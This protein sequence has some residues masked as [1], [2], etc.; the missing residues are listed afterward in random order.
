M[1]ILFKPASTLLGKLVMIPSLFC[2]LEAN[3]NPYALED[4]TY[5]VLEPF[6]YYF[7][8]RNTQPPSLVIVNNISGSVRTKCIASPDSLAYLAVSRSDGPLYYPVE[9]KYYLTA[10]FMR[11]FL[12]T[13]GSGSVSYVTAHEIAHGFQFQAGINLPPPFHEQQADCLAGAVM[14]MN[15]FTK[16]ELS[17]AVSAAEDCGG[18]T[19][20]GKG[21]DR[22]KAVRRGFSEGFLSCLK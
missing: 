3:A 2:S 5:K 20:H 17:E 19:T 15:G 22:A 16:K 13:H 18:G 8:T 10:D 6:D 12:E 1:G 14:G 7:A 21:T 11:D 9:H 4:A